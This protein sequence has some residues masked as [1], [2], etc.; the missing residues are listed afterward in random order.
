VDY[1]ETRNDIEKTFG[2]VPGFFDG[3]PRDLLVQM[4]PSVKTYMIG[5]TRIPAKYREL[6]GLGV[7]MALKCAPCEAFHG[8]A[9]RMNG[10]SEEELAELKSIVGQVSYWSSMAQAMNYDMGSFMREFQAMAERFASRPG[11]AAK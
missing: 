9:A 10:A 7:A 8:S 4:W 1:Q 5:Q 3:V 11:G 6:I 2:S